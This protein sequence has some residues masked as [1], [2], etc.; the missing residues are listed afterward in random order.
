MV[1]AFYAA[2]TISSAGNGVSAGVFA[3]FTLADLPPLQRV[4]GTNDL[5]PRELL[6]LATFPLVVWGS[7]E[8]RRWFMRRREARRR[9]RAPAAKN[10]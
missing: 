5:G 3:I 2:D 6:L 9:E 8:L 1:I 4:F 7:D 10:S